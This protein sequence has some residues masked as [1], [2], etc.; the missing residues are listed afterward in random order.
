[1]LLPSPR[2]SRLL[3][4]ALVLVGMLGACETET[5]EVTHVVQ[6]E[7][8]RVVREEVT[9]VVIETVEVTRLVTEEGEVTRAAERTLEEE[10]PDVP[11]TLNINAG[12]EPTTLDPSLA[13]LADTAAVTIIRNLFVTLTQFDPETGEV[14]PYLATEWI[15]G[16]DGEGNRT[17]TFSL[18]EDVPWMKYNPTR[19]EFTQSTDDD[20]TPRFV[21]AHDVVYGVKRTLDPETASD[22]A[23]LLYIVKNA[24]AV[25]TGAGGFTVAD[26]GVEALDNSTL[27]FTLEHEAPYFPAIAGLPVAAPMPEWAIAERPKRW[28]EPGFIVTNGPYGLDTWIH[29]SQ[30]RLVKNPLYPWAED[31]QIER[32]EALMLEE[33]SEAFALYENNELDTTDVPLPEMDRVRADPTLSEELEIAPAGCTYY[34]GFNNQKP[35]FDDARVRRA[36]S[37]AIDRRSLIDNVLNGGQIPATSFAPPGIVG[38][39]EPGAVGLGYNAQLAQQAL[40]T[41]LD[42]QGMTVQ[43]FNRSYDIL[44]MHNTGEGHAQI[45]SAIQQMWNDTLDVEVSIEDR[46]WQA[47]LDTIHKN[48]PIAEAPHIYRFGWCADYP[49][50][51][52][53]VHDLFNAQDGANRVRRNCEDANCSSATTTEFDELSPGRGYPGPRGGRVCPHLSLHASRRDKTVARS[54]LP[55][56][57]R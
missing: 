33:T 13:L 56:H 51:N 57:W 36:F 38:A 41:F 28:I 48:T 4:V 42:E 26:F 31:V 45:A 19:G 34:Y 39:P 5:V 53:W 46:E 10:I 54:E 17:W 6:E 29:G 25:N 44:L 37:A 30:L 22:Y 23:F 40:Q 8:T 16:E 52:N 27:R 15:S 3:L 14:Q 47:H 1:M 7:V 35:P 20:G 24:E 32:I 11:V 2:R 55:G 12:A 9:R 43:D 50:E 49:D 18:R 21:T